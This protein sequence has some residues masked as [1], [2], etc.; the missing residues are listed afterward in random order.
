MPDC[1]IISHVAIWLFAVPKES[2][3]SNWSKN[4]KSAIVWVVQKPFSS[5][6]NVSSL[7]IIFLKF[8]FLTVDGKAAA[9]LSS[10]TS[11]AVEVS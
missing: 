7:K 6:Y 1:E 8:I 11:P 5:K 10:C 4:S 3:L 2:W 9:S